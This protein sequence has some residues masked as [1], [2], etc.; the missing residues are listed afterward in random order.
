MWVEISGLHVELKWKQ[1]PKSSINEVLS[2]DGSYG[3]PSIVGGAKFLLNI[4]VLESWRMLLLSP[5]WGST[6]RFRFAFYAW[7]RV[8]LKIPVYLAAL[9]A[10]GIV[11]IN[12]TA[13][14]MFFVSFNKNRAAVLRLEEV[15][16]KRWSTFTI[17]HLPQPHKLAKSAAKQLRWISKRLPARVH[18][19]CVRFQFN[20]W[21]A[22]RRYQRRDPC[23]MFCKTGDAEDSI[24]HFIY[25]NAIQDLFLS[26]M[27]AYHANGVPPSHFSCMD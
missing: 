3:V 10:S 14:N 27:K 13:Y 17:L 11:N 6:L 9:Q 2:C 19:A 1:I 21:H 20:G 25:C 4:A 22:G 23:C 26:P 12:K 8:E 24:E 7:C 18:R 15:Y 5:F 16:R